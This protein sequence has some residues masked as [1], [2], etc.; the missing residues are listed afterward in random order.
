VTRPDPAEL[1]KTANNLRVDGWERAQAVNALAAEVVALRAELAEAKADIQ[2]EAAV[3]EHMR[4]ERDRERAAREAAER[5][6][7]E[8]LARP[9]DLQLIEG[10]G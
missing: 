8:A 7:D 5:E 6:R 1:A 3:S 2:I 9:A 10:R 4:E